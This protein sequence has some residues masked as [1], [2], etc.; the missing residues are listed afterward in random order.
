VIFVLTAGQTGSERRRLVRKRGGEDEIAI[1]ERLFRLLSESLR[2]VV[3]RT[4][5][6]SELAVINAVQVARCA[7][8]RLAYGA[9]SRSIAR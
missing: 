2:L 1:L 3:L 9:L 8:E 6:R 4:A 5:F 7:S